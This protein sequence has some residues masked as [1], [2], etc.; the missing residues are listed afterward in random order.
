MKL[1]EKLMPQD[2]RTRWN[3]TFDM[4]DFAITHAKALDQLTG[5]RNNNLR[6]FELSAGKW[7]IVKDL[8][9]VL[10]VSHVF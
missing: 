1:T 5:D 2:V 9:N 10:K 6:A 4:L 3:S 8:R 7:T